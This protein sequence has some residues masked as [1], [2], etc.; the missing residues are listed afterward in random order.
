M[1]RANE[2]DRAIVPETARWGYGNTRNTWLSSQSSVRSWFPQRTSILL[3]QLRNAGLYPQINAP[4]FT[5]AGG[6]VP[7]GYGLALVNPN[8]SGTIY[9]STDG[10]D[11]RLWGGAPAPGAQIY[12]T[13]LLLTNALPLRARV[14]D[15]GNWSALVEATFYVVQDFTGL[16][17]TEI[18]YR[19]PSFAPWSGDDLEFLELKNTGLKTID[20]SGLT[21]TSGLDFTFTNGTRLA[22]GAF[23]LLARNPAAFAARYPGVSVSGVYSNK[24]DNSGEKITLRHLLGP[25]VFTATYSHAS[26]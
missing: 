7:P 17:V 13:P 23:F 8:P 3:N 14:R 15:G 1:R 26:P 5:P 9:F 2:I 10:S 25:N 18:M 19:P 20:F 4:S 24:L 16:A 21:F 12:A 22:S 6:L 11:P